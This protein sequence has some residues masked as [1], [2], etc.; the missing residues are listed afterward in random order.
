[1][2]NLKR[3]INMG[4]RVTSEEQEMIKR[5][6]EQTGIQNLRAYLLKMAVDGMVVN[7]DLSEVNECSRLL[8]NI[9]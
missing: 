7:L 9:G 8:R 1:M 4:F 3:N 2:Q 5:R 6:Q